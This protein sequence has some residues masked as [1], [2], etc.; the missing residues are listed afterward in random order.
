MLT[1]KLQ[2]FLSQAGIASRRAAEE[3]IKAGKISVNGQV[4]KIGH[5]VDPNKDTIEVEGKNISISENPRYFLIYKPIGVVSTTEDE[6]GRKTVISL[7]PK[8]TVKNSR[9]YPVGRLDLESKGLM[10]LTSDG[11]LT[12]KLTHPRFGMPKTYHVLVDR[13][14]SYRALEHLEKGVMLK[15]GLTAPAGVEMLDKSGKNQWLKIT[16]HEGRNRQVRR[17]MERVGYETLRLVRT[18]LGP[19]SL[20][21]LQGKTYRELSVDQ[22]EQKLSDYDDENVLNRS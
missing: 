20:S 21:D 14:P 22:I 9:L 1:I 7:L 15:E 6:L 3:L 18:N 11:A 10:L 2:K 12:H 17:M 8:E 16:I 19:F 4:A 5:R 13:E